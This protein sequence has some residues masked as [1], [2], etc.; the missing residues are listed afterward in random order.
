VDDDEYTRVF[1]QRFLPAS[2]RT[3]AAAN[4]RE[5]VESVRQDP[6]DA[7]IMDLD[8]PVMGGLEAAALI[9]QWEAESGRARCAM[10]AM[11][12][13]DDPAIAARCG[14]AGFDR[15]L[16]KPV[17]PDALRRTLSELSSSKETVVVDPDLRDALPGFLASR[18]EMVDALARAVAAGT[19]EPARALAHKLAG[20]FALYGFHWAAGQ[21]KMI[22]KR[23][24]ENRMDGL[25]AEVDALR[26][27]LD[28]VQVGTGRRKLAEEQE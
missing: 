16:A 26:R 19:A 23:A 13:H 4:G 9:R 10:I 12:S 14:Q 25:A 22:E 5:A 15:Y 18:R 21:G 6:P 8:M 28:G 27:H 17:S 2:M 3:R 20:S 24:R 1:V 11:S 7:I